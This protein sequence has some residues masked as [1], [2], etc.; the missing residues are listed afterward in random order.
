MVQFESWNKY[1]QDL[2]IFL[3]RFIY[4]KLKQLCWPRVL[5][6]NAEVA[7][8]A[9]P[10][11]FSVI[12]TLEFRPIRE[13]EVWARENFACGW[14][15][16][17]GKL[18][19]N[20]D[21]TDLC[22]EFFNDGEGLL[23]DGEGNPVKGFTAGSVVFGVM[24]DSIEK[25]YYPLEDFI[26]ADGSI[27]CYI[28]GASN[29]LLGEFHGA[30]KMEKA[31]V[32]R[33]NAAYLDLF[34]DFDTLYESLRSID[35]DDP[36]KLKLLYGL[37]AAENLINYQDPDFYQKAKAIF[38]GLYALPGS[39]TV[40]A[41]AVAHSHLDLAW[42]WPIRESKRKAKRTFA[43]LVFL[44]KT[45]PS[46]RFVVSQ[47]QQLAW[48]KESEPALYRELKALAK[49][50]NLEPVGGGWVE[51]DTNLPGEESLARQMLYGQKFWQEEFGAYV[52][53]CWLPDAFGYCGALPQIIRLSGQE[54]FMTIKIS[55]SNRTVFPYNTF[56]W[57]GI[58]GSE[59]TVHM[60]PEGNYNSVAGPR[61]LL[62]AKKGIKKTDPQDRMMLVYGVGDG[63]GGPSANSVER[64]L[65]TR[66][67]PYLPH[68]EF[69]TAAEY[70]RALQPQTLPQYDGEMYLE[71]HRGTYTSQSNNKNYNREFEE[72]MSSLESLL[73][74]LGRRGDPEA[75]D[76]LWK[77]ALLYQFHDI[78]PGSSISRV[79]AETT[80]A[81][82]RMFAELESMAKQLDATFLPGGRLINPG[83]EEVFC[84]E[85][86][87]GT[88]LLYRGSDALIAP[89]SCGQAVE[90][91]G[92][93]SVETDFYRAEFAPDGSFKRI[94][95][96]NGEPI[97]RS[98]NRLRVFIDVGDAWD[99]E[100]DYRDQREVYAELESTA[101]RRFGDLTEIRQ[102]YR[103]RD[104]RIVQT[105]LMHRSDP[106]IRITHDIDWNNIG[107]MLRAEFLP[108]H[109]SDTVHSD[110][111]FGYLDR[112]TTDDTAHEKAQFEMCC[113][114]WFD[115]SDEAAGL[116]VLNNAKNGFMAKQ[117]ILSLNLLRSTDYPAT[118]G[119]CTPLHYSYALYP[120]AGGFDPLKT[121]SLA[122]QFTARYLYGDCCAD[123]P[124]FD[125]DRIRV[126]AFKPA[127]DGDGFILRAFERTGQSVQTK[128]HLPD[129]WR[130]DGEV[131]L[132]ED[133]IGD[134]EENISF[135]PFQIRSWRLHNQIHLESDL[136][137]RTI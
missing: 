91:N 12:S 68:T 123:M 93:E 131:D 127:Y 24:D 105:I 133:P 111:Q 64:C 16:L 70:F 57:A 98:A 94:C 71:K 18:P 90:L 124:A 13:G 61:A 11:P 50:G 77:E 119:E 78:L 95:L 48:M 102:V 2:E 76:R 101:A 87:G 23:V 136:Q 82:E 28:D 117:G 4:Q 7:C 92:I 126:T 29:N 114:K 27:E 49:K 56:R 39:E 63:G 106:C 112:P 62:A 135:R 113:Q 17:T 129:G 37:R 40:K 99:F 109:W 53:T 97:A 72:K 46:F 44:A 33:K 89:V 35:Y 8:S 96:A 69:G 85:P 83:R 1:E 103:F 110:I 104:S 118:E 74:C 43:N 121:D 25:R 120:H 108:E 115:L 58:D 51:C 60:P 10:V 41:T 107:Y 67:V 84:P 122:Q 66:N 26:G 52:K 59:V 132:L 54:N 100:D 36:N 130:L 45:Y 32:V 15:R 81:Y 86:Y 3:G 9:E 30:A 31:A 34:Y 116:S 6:L 137:R 88:Y 73:S 19:E 65:R 55:W 14:F 125:N 80:A 134:G 42:L 128:L 75:I 47:P 38:A 20:T 22:L 79:Y 21:R 5:P